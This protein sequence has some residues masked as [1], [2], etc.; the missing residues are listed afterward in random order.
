MSDEANA[1]V[2]SV[3]NLDSPGEIR[4]STTQAR[5]DKGKVHRCRHGVLAG[6][7]VEALSH[8][9][10]HPKT[11]RRL[12]KKFRAA[13]KVEGI[14]GDLVFDY[15][16]S[17]ALRVMLIGRLEATAVKSLCAGSKPE[18]PLPLL[19][20]LILQQDSNQ[21]G[22]I[23]TFPGDVQ[24]DVF[25]VLAVAQRYHAHH[26]RIVE[27][28]LALLVVLSEGGETALVD[29]VKNLLEMK[30]PHGKESIK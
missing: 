16:W 28:M 27:R 24:P 13:L 11:I 9:G 5:K 19:P 30:Y 15:W 29:C 23:Q 12:E 17:S 1:S 21:I 20:P 4:S 7:V 18:S 14:L 3:A 10:E 8:L 2:P 25:R 22:S 6:S 26:G